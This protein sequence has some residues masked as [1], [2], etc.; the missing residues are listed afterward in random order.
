MNKITLDM[1]LANFFDLIKDN[2]N[3]G[4][5]VDDPSTRF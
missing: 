2:L 5:E 1:K 3:Y 4:E